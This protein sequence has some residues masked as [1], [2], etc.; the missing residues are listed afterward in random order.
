MSFSKLR[1]VE[2]ITP[3]VI[4]HTFGYQAIIYVLLTVLSNAYEHRCIQYELLRGKALWVGVKLTYLHNA[5]K[6]L[7]K[8]YQEKNQCN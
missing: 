6:S 2:L 1:F 4:I 3:P 5:T 7:D 8:T